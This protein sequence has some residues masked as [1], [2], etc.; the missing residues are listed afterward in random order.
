MPRDPKYLVL[1]ELDALNRNMFS[2]KHRQKDDHVLCV[3]VARP[4]AAHHRTPM[5][6]LALGANLEYLAVVQ[7]S[8]GDDISLAFA[9]EALIGPEDMPEC[10]LVIYPLL[11]SNGG[12]VANYDAALQKL[13][14]LVLNAAGVPVIAFLRDPDRTTIR[15]AIAAGAYD[16]FVESGSMPELRII[17]RRAAHFHELS[18]ELKRVQ[19]SPGAGFGSM[20]AADPRML[21]LVALSRRV[22]TSDASIMITGETGTGKELLAAAIHDASSRR[23][24]PFIPVACS[25]LP[26]T[27]IEAEL[28]GHERGAFTGAAAA[29]V[30][31]FEAAGRGTIFIDEVGELSPA[32][33][34]KLLRV[35]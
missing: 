16:Y 35:L 24:F 7:S 25:A 19:T 1:R 8:L 3:S 2:A 10:D 13:R 26:E 12:S 14:Q 30:G 27:L 20:L 31:R 23:R 4:Q 6:I 32:L 21:E 29:R 28:F 11:K 22:A 18:A 34:V 33:Q 9:D 5:K 17:L 15:E